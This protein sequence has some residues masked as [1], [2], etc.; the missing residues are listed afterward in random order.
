MKSSS[1]C[2]SMQLIR[3]LSAALL[4]LSLLP[5]LSSAH[6]T[7]IYF[8]ET[9]DASD[10][11]SSVLFMFDTSGSMTSWDGT[12]YSR[13][14]R[15]KQAMNDVVD[16]ADNVN[17]GIGAFNGQVKGGSILLPA[18]NLD[19]E[20]CSGAVCDDLV[21]RA[22]IRNGSDDAQEQPSGDV[23]LDNPNLSIDYG[24]AS[25]DVVSNV[26]YV[27]A[28]EDDVVESVSGGM[29]LGST[30]LSMFFNDDVLSSAY[31]E[32]AVGIRFPGV[33]IPA[34]ATLLEATLYL[35]TRADGDF[36]DVSAVISL[37][38][39]SSAP[40]FAD[41]AGQRV[42]DRPLHPVQVPWSNIPATN[43][44]WYSVASPSLIGLIDETINA[45]GWNGTGDLAFV[46]QPDALHT[47]DIDNRRAFSSYEFGYS[48][49]LVIKYTT[50]APDNTL[51]GLRFSDLN[52]PQGA[53]IERAVL[54]LTP[55]GGGS[56]PTQVRVV[57]EATDNAVTFLPGNSSL[58]NRIN[59]SSQHTAADV[60]WDIERWNMNS[61]YW[62]S[63]DISA[64][65]NEI[66]QRPGWC[67]GNSVALYLEGM[68]DRRFVSFDRDPWFAPALEVTYDPSSVDF[69]DT[70]LRQRTAAVV[71]G[72]SND[73]IESVV[74]GSIDAAANMLRTSDGI[75][76]QS[77]GL[78]FQSIDVPANATISSAYLQL[79]SAG[80][81]T[82]DVHLAIDIQ[83]SASA[84]QFSA[85]DNSLS[86]RTYSGSPVAW[87]NVPETPA[88]S[89]SRSPD[90]TSLIQGMVNRGGWV[91]GNSA[92]IKMDVA[93]GST[94]QRMFV[95]G[96]AAGSGGAR[97]IVQYQQTGSDLNG[98]PAPLVTGR[99]EIKRQI[100][101]L[102]ANGG[103]PLVD[104]LYEAGQYMRGGDV[105]FGKLRGSQ[106]SAD[107]IH[108]V[109]SARSYTG[110]TLYRPPGC[111]ESDLN[112]IAC[113]SEEIQGNPVYNMPDVSEC[114]ANQI[115]FLSDGAATSNNA[116]S[117]IQS[118]AGKSS[119]EARENDSETC[120][121]ELAKWLFETDHDSNLDGTQG[122]VTHSVGFNFSSPFLKDVA[123]AGGG[124]FYTAD[125][126]SDLTQA[127]NNI[128]QTA[129]SLD[130][131]FVAPSASISQTNRLVYSNDIY[132]GS[133]R[134]DTTTK[135]DGN[136]KKYQ[137]AANTTTGKVEILDA[138][139]QPAF[140]ATTGALKP[141]SK[142]FWS[143]A[144]DG[145]SI[146][147]G[148]AASKL[149]LSRSL[150]TSMPNATNGKIELF[151][152][153]ES[154]AA[155]TEDM[156]G[157]SGA[158]AEYRTSLLQWARGVD[159]KDYDNDGD[160]LEVRAQMGD[161]LHS[162]QYVLNY[163]ESDTQNKT[164]IFMGTN[165]G[166]VHAIDTESGVEEFAFIP[167][168]LLSN[169]DYFFKDESV[170]HDQRPYGL[171]G[172]ITGWHDDTN[173][174][175][176]V[177]ND[178]TA[179]IYIGMR[180]G[181]SN[182]YA[183]DVSDPAAPQFKWMIE[184]GSGDFA[185][186]GQTWSRPVKSRVKYGGAVKD[187]LI[188]AGGYDTDKDAQTVRNPDSHGAAI[189]MVDATTGAYLTSRD[190]LDFSDMVYSIPSDI[191]VINIDSD[192]LAD[193][194]FVGDTGGQLWRF[195]I[196]N[197]ANNDS[198]FLRGGVIADLGNLG[199][200]NNRRF[201]YEPDVSLIRDSAG[202]SYLN[203]AIG[204]GFR[205]HPNDLNVTDRFYS[206]R[207]N[208]IFGPPRDTSGD[209]SYSAAK[210]SESDLLDVST[211]SGK[212][213]T[214][215][216]LA[217]GWY[218][219][220]PD[221]GEKV[222]SSSLTVDNIINFTTYVPPVSQVSACSV[223][224]G[225]GR[226]YSVDVFYG[227]PVDATNAADGSVDNT[228]RYVILATPGIPPR[229]SGLITEANPN[230]ITELVGL[231]VIDD[232][233]SGQPFERTFWAE[234]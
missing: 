121:V 67:A 28:P 9:L 123:A 60:T 213:D 182:Y 81:E 149:A 90:L 185:E 92:L 111:L 157:I 211:Q 231:E 150:Y 233:G 219:N 124:N 161:P 21:V 47:P 126:A 141:S 44:D 208:S 202:S 49:E 108:S 31:G 171:D 170:E 46:I 76:E 8:A 86:S 57:G 154:N 62:D 187:V 83:A 210:V 174:N 188:F 80:F 159:V 140:D 144:A 66:T 79:T 201:F 178:E 53:T 135:W 179:T 87:N 132:Y 5:V 205:A 197:S 56:S 39:R 114:T 173:E 71:S 189:F 35:G 85:T 143:S 122:I 151:D 3:G 19:E 33:N 113:I 107:R 115:V 69:S 168:E 43:M 77:I 176:L 203:V 184:G 152:F 32:N 139:M 93:T 223:S 13:M 10:A 165:E 88:G 42:L 217:S 99:E 138:L 70:C 89:S 116:V 119:C 25:S 45:V 82:G 12:G 160:T 63:I 75:D 74:D 59:S 200:A 24:L 100:M 50:E 195:D 214:S 156:L 230:G 216:K 16:S 91:S 101:G 128:I 147:K 41:V 218:F 26:Y 234:Y 72:G 192:G 204:S 225:S 163:K 172:E 22:E 112:D 209:V 23:S 181:G 94:G 206:I 169:L 146:S 142:S 199:Q 229:V 148:G 227:D 51:I 14:S 167:E 134:P 55:N 133:F 162:T 110:G 104:M 190:E 137:L 158:E 105:S 1:R 30:D 17:I 186:L 40:A 180:R 136:L 226:V 27:N 7:E 64:V 61:V 224:I 177:D 129:I 20:L 103:T 48:P 29:D 68:G 96:D 52:V 222:L 221:T 15:L 220:M 11:E 37:D 228:D 102:H 4:T 109:S 212:G 175:G 196:D 153:H 54:K 65:L 191:R 194:L 215:G 125:S 232:G 131:G 97:L 166:F 117:N 183:I 73:L 155:I 34:G 95:S 130:S 6:D 84:A 18:I 127:F 38:S 193:M 118:L 120:G 78:R 106:R 58:S 98:S 198:G 36:G 2:E 207:Q 164:L 145:D